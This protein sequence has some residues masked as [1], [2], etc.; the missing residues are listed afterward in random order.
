MSVSITLPPSLEESLRRD[1][2]DLEQH[3]K[4]ALLIDLYRRERITKPQ[5]A[6]A[7]SMTR[8][9]V[10]DVLN[11]WNVTE[12][13]PSVDEVFSAAEALASLREHAG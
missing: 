3:A 7:L 5:L 1:I 11:R 4:E 2:A 6:A 12:D 13:L 10:N 9:E 8:F